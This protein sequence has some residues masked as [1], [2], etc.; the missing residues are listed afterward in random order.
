MT[1]SYG[2][3]KAISEVPNELINDL[4]LLFFIFFLLFELIDFLR[5]HSNSFKMLSMLVHKEKSSH[6]Q[7]ALSG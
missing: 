2:V 3:D 1:N 6:L 4:G 7:K 5:K